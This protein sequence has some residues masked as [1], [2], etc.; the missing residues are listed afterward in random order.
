MKK[1][2]KLRP[3]Q[4][5]CLDIIH[6]LDKGSY[7][8][9]MS[10]GSGKTIVFTSIKPRGRMLIL[11]HRDELVKQPIKYLS[12]PVG[13]EKA[14]ST[15]NGE[16]VVVASVQSLANRLHKFNRD[17][18]DV[19]ITD[20]AAHAVA[21]TYL[22]I[23]DYFN[24]RLHI[25]VTAT[26]A[27][28]DKQ[29]LDKVFERIIFEKS[30]L[31][32]MQE[33]W[34]C[35]LECK[36]VSIDYN[37]NNVKTDGGDFQQQMLAD[38]MNGTHIGI[39]KA[40]LELAR[41]QTIVF[42]SGVK[43]GHDIASLLPDSVMVDAKTENRDEI[44][45]DFEEGKIKYLVN[46]MIF[47]EGTDLPMT[48]TVVMA[49]PT[50][51][52]SLYTQC[53]GRCLRLYE[54]KK[55]ALLIDCVG[56]SRLPICTAPSLLGLDIKHIP[57]KNR[58]KLEGDLFDLEEKVIREYDIFENWKINYKIVNLWAKEQYYNTYNINFF[59]FPN[60]D[61][62]LSLPN[63][64]FII[65]GQDELGYTLFKG[66][67]MRMQEAIDDVFTTLK[68]DYAKEQV[69]WDLS[70]V[71]KWADRPASEKQLALISKKIKNADTTDMTMLEANQVINKIAN[72]WKKDIVIC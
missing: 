55:S 3:Y 20:E 17:H 27:R 13:I 6:S 72:K 24:A 21:P 52:I 69:F 67:K 5:E 71:K 18:F 47:T 28:A 30:M 33:G 22:Q 8:V 58:A 16:D 44:I 37:L 38:A 36:R 34:L 32:C 59:K 19:I 7:L 53:I 64:K 9:Q 68:R 41:G 57:E 62:T 1:N 50:R 25:G 54:G 29:G 48:E 40:I 56:V 31:E 23:Y 43:H 35:P 42:A 46:N 4:Q 49:R 70:I 15:S 66:K 11:A 12:K 14:K 2:L 10:V 39:V 63:V 51:N 26:P 61:L 65:Q 45:K 60:G